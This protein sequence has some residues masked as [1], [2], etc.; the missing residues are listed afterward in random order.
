MFRWDWRIVEFEIIS[1]NFFFGLRN[2]IDWIIR[3]IIM[4][5]IL[6]NCFKSSVKIKKNL[7]LRSYDPYDEPGE[8]KASPFNLSFRMKSDRN[9][10]DCTE[11]SKK[12]FSIICSVRL[13]VWES[14]IRFESNN[15]DCLIWSLFCSLEN[16]IWFW[17]RSA[18]FNLL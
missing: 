3:L 8:R 7:D 5:L 2:H 4:K 11:S 13:E 6:F 16:E 1:L 14:I 10:V 18:T 15:W 12:F 9:S 17:D